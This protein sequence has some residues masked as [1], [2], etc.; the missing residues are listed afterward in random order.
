VDDFPY[1]LPMLLDGGAATNL[2]AAG[3]PDDVCMEQWAAEHPDVLRAVQKGFLAA[4]S[5]TILA[6]TFR[7]NRSSLAQYGL[8]EKVEELNRRLVVMSRE[9]ANGHLVGALVGPS[10]LL[11]PPH[12]DADFDDV[13]DIYREQVRALENAGADFLLAASQTSL[14]DMRALVLAARTNDL[15][16]FV[17]IAV[18]EDGRTP[19]N[20]T[21]LPVLL[22]LQ[23]MGAD[24]VGLNFACSPD[25]MIPLMKDAASHTEIPLIA[26]PSN[27]SMEPQEWAQSMRRLMDAG[28]S[29]VGG[30]LSTTPAHILALKPLLKGFMPPKVPEE[31]DCYA[32]AIE[33]EAFFLADDLMFSR[34]L[35]CS[36]KLDDE[37][38]ALDDEQASV[39]LVCV[40]DLADADILAAAA[41][42]TRQP[43]AVHADSKPIL[44]AALRYFQGRL[45][46]D[47]SCEIEPE[48]LE[49]LA[50]K[51]GAILY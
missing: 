44:D 6:P 49:P 22:T 19:T 21:L 30:C 8:A 13:Y 7:A 40:N 29:I 31:P 34:P 37:L 2:S 47:S 38:I 32:A 15:P 17:T 50:K 5:D 35:M 39:T 16:V 24:A 25:T 4:G 42:L 9:N 33:S 27:S 48:V 11:V 23:A 12:G 3:M 18:D 20:A 1:P 36:A 28:A 14:S 43:I 51:Y 26:R 46:I 45:I 10:S 41:H